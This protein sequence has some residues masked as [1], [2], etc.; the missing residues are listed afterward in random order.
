MTEKRPSPVLPGVRTPRWVAGNP[1][2]WNPA[3]P[4]LTSVLKAVDE[5]Q[6]QREAE[7]KK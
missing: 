4:P 5:A 6:R 7:K 3:Q 1:H 2:G